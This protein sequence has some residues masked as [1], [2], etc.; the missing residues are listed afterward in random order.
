M[1]EETSNGPR[2][3]EA[4]PSLTGGKK[5]LLYWSHQ[6]IVE[7]EIAKAKENFGTF[8]TG[9]GIKS[10]VI[11]ALT[12][13]Y[14]ANVQYFK[15]NIHWPAHGEYHL[16][17]DINW[18][19]E[20]FNFRQKQD[21]F[22]LPEP[23]RV[24]TGLA[25]ICALIDHDRGDVPRQGEVFAQSRRHEHRSIE[26]SHSFINDS[27]AGLEL[28]EGM[29]ID[30]LKELSRLI[31]ASTYPPLNLTYND[32]EELDEMAMSR[33]LQAIPEE[34][35]LVNDA[36]GQVM[37]NEITTAREKLNGLD[38]QNS[39]LL[40]L[41]RIADA[42]DT[43]ISYSA[44]L[45]L[46]EVIALVG[47]FNQLY[48]ESGQIKTITERKVALD[49]FLASIH[50]QRL[51][52][53]YG[54][55]LPE[56]AKALV[57]RRLEIEAKLR[58]IIGQDKR[59]PLR[60]MEGSFTAFSLNELAQKFELAEP[61]KD[62]LINYSQEMMTVLQSADPANFSRL[63]TDLIRKMYQA[64]KEDRKTEFIKDLLIAV[65]N[66]EQNVRPTIHLSPFAYPEDF[67]ENLK[68][69]LNELQKGPIE[70]EVVAALR[71]D[72]D[73]ELEKAEQ[74]SDLDVSFAF[75][76]KTNADQLNQGFEKDFK[77]VLVHVGLNESQGE[78][79]EALNVIL[80]NSGKLAPNAG[81]HL[82]GNY[83]W[84]L[85]WYQGLSDNDKK[86]WGSFNLIVSPII[87]LM[88]NKKT[89]ACLNQM[90]ALGLQVKLASN[91]S[92][93]TGEIGL[94]LAY[95]ATGWRPATKSQD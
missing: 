31:I 26:D 57:A 66:S 35:K 32:K 83:E 8:L 13:R 44:D 18:A 10:E 73:G 12:A 9:L 34:V 62:E 86:K 95:L 17:K 76:G 23:K 30:E 81:I 27:L 78:M 64:V 6:E 56:K 79:Q 52:A 42:A 80:N 89:L 87:H 41:C 70:V 11:N 43:G 71:L 3:L 21:D 84:F 63:A 93:L 94:N 47:E 46:I 40:E 7:P 68:S 16:A 25:L 29:S 33:L 59:D 61:M 50:T 55:Y 51:N 58:E 39:E 22:P 37:I 20:I 60:R 24:K 2:L 65:Q 19:I 38:W 90:K 74:L 5:D 15:D 14:D 82:D 85:N 48:E 54:A 45:S 72:R 1:S 67:V 4:R 75:C 91:N 92:A 49:N 69:A 53:L 88:R 36:H 28:P 77:P